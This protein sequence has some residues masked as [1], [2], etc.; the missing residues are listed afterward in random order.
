MSGDHED[1]AKLIEPLK[2]LLQIRSP[3]EWLLLG[4]QEGQDTKE[5]K[6]EGGEPAHRFILA[7]GFE[8][9]FLRFLTAMSHEVDDGAL[10]KP[11]RNSHHVQEPPTVP[12]ESRGICTELARQQSRPK[13]RKSA[14]SR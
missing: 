1:R 9:P 11:A 7:S 3:G 14:R 6:E 13:C 8:L 5:Q 10:I 2:R 12:D 4:W